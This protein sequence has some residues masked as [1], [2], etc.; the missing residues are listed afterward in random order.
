MSVRR[1][2]LQYVIAHHENKG[3]ELLRVPLEAGDKK[4][5]PVFSFEESAR[6]FLRHGNL[7]PEWYV[8]ESS[9]GELSS[10]LL[11]LHADVCW[12]LPDPLPQPLAAEDALPNLVDRRSFVSF[13]LAS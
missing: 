7:G 5:L 4:A 9:N 11:G 2:T 10:L 12:V 3:L 13:L 8:R 1:A 6:K